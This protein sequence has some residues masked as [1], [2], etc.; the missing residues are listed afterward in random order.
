LTDI[1]EFHED[2]ASIDQKMSSIVEDLVWDTSVELTGSK[3]LE[4]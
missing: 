4:K 2:K 3:N 1:V